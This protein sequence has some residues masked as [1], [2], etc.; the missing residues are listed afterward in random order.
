[1]NL[2]SPSHLPLDVPQYPSSCVEARPCEFLRYKPNFNWSC[3]L[4]FVVIHL[5]TYE[6]QNQTWFVQPF[7]KIAIMFTTFRIPLGW[8][9]RGV[10]SKLARFDGKCNLDTWNL[11]PNYYLNLQ[12]FHLLVSNL[13]GEHMCMSRYIYIY[14]YIWSP[15]KKYLFHFSSYFQ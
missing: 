8:P 11:N 1:M 14:L 12:A 3:L 2:P 4:D 5:D 6:I 9:T 10:D 15:P 7:L 13:Y